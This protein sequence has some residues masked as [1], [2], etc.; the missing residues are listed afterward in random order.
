M[1][2]QTGNGKHEKISK[3]KFQKSITGWQQCLHYAWI[4]PTTIFI[5]S[6]DHSFGCPVIYM[7]TIHDAILFTDTST[8][9][10]TIKLII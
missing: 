6:N 1:M 4:S 10:D 7:D 3:W 5:T 8:I 2:Q 9:R